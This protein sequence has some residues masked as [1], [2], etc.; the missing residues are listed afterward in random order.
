MAPSRGRPTEPT[1]RGRAGVDYGQNNGDRT[2][3]HSRESGI[4]FVD[5]V[6]ELPNSPVRR[7]A[8]AG[9]GVY[10]VRLLDFSRG[11]GN[12]LVPDEEAGIDPD[13]VVGSAGCGSG[14]SP[15]CGGGI[16]GD[17]KEEEDDD[18][19]PLPYDS[20]HSVAVF[21]LD[22]RTNRT[23][24]SDGLAGWRPDP[25]GDFLG[26]EQWLWF[27]TAL[28]R[29][30]ASVNVIVTGLQV[31]PNRF[32]SAQVAEEWTK[33]PLSRRRLYDT[34]LSSEVEAPIFVSGDVHMAQFMRKDCFRVG[35]EGDVIHSKDD[36]D[37]RDSDDNLGRPLME[38]TTSGLTHS[39]GT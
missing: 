23:P 11:P 9:R 10:G 5:F 29:S 14:P 32:P 19:G 17:D 8:T 21:F 22:V 15:M 33:F 36:S 3:V 24:W 1:C 2:Y 37:D 13:L 38:M 16:S 27:E 18:E 31:H 7:R 28:R 6:G 30:L 26:E 34:V 25:G 20:K 12:E 39:W 4:A 35:R